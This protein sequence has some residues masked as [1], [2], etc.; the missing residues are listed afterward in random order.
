MANRPGFSRLVKAFC[1]KW[2]DQVEEQK[3]ID[4]L[5]TKASLAAFSANQSTCED[6]LEMTYQVALASDPR[7]VKTEAA[8][9]KLATIP[10]PPSSNPRTPLHDTYAIGSTTWNAVRLYADT[11]LDG[12]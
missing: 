4:L 3:E 5:F 6:S 9:S 11:K 2:L 12:C 8:G 10:D 1:D 7:V